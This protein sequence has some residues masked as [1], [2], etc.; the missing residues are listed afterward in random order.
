MTEKETF[1]ARK[2][3]RA[4]LNVFG[5]DFT[6]E[7]FQAFEALGTFLSQHQRVLFFLQ[8]RHIDDQKKQVIL[9]DIVTK[10]KIPASFMHLVN[11]LLKDKR[12]SLLE[13]VVNQVANL[14]KELNHVIP[15]AITTSHELNE[16]SC[17]IIRN[18]IAQKTSCIVLA[19]KTVDPTLI[20]GLRIQSDTLLWEYSVRKQLQQIRN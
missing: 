5:N 20:A 18:F 15:I 4:Y 2:Y 9:Q 11:L 17:A 13:E 6:I 8:L 10:L 3:A 1:V 19:H 14:Y 12:A 16:T 7:Q